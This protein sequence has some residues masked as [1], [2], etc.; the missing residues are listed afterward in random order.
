MPW[1]GLTVGPSAR[2]QFAFPL[3]RGKQYPIPKSRTP[4]GL[5]SSAWRSFLQK[6]YWKILMVFGIIRVI[7]EYVIFARFFSSPGVYA[8]ELRLPSWLFFS[9]FAPFSGEKR[10]KRFLLPFPQ[11]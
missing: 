3:V 6:H 7:V 10:K 9:F 2:R 1:A 11:A 4:L 5:P 8:W